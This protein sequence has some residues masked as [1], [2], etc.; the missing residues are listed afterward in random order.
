MED[1][2]L[3]RGLENTIGKSNTP[4]GVFFSCSSVLQVLE[5]GKGNARLGKVNWGS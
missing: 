1:Y 4:L 3:Q 2:I 5:I